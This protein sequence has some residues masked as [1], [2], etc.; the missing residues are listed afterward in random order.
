M[1]AS[2]VLQKEKGPEAGASGPAGC[3]R[4]GVSA[5]W[6]PGERLHHTGDAGSISGAAT[7][8]GGAEQR[9]DQGKPTRP[10]PARPAIL[11]CYR[12]EVTSKLS[13][14]LA[15]RPSRGYNL[16]IVFRTPVCQCS[17]CRCRT[18]EVPAAAVRLFG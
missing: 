12:G 8:G 17:C 13:P 11:T 3:R 1:S 9:H 14:S 16:A 15:T 18:S 4:V 5:S 7:T 2:K 10:A 6:A